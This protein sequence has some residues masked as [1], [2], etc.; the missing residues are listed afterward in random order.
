MN[1]DTKVE[2]GDIVWDYD[3]GD[4]G[5]AI[6]DGQSE[7]EDIVWEYSADGDITYMT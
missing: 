1:E 6:N 7:D 5:T 4:E 3:F 2:E